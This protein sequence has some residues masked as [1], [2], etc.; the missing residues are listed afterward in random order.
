MVEVVD[1]H[2]GCGDRLGSQFHNCREVH[3]AWTRFP[4][5]ERSLAE[6]GP[7]VS[8]A[9]KSV[10]ATGSRRSGRKNAIIV[11]DKDYCYKTIVYGKLLA[12]NQE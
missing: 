6:G 2:A 3:G 11:I 5:L 12:H 4:K 7:C 10:F 1:L 8:L 9:G